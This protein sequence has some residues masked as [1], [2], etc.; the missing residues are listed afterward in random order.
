MSHC[1]SK[2]KKS[3]RIK[4]LYTFLFLIPLL[5]NA[6]Q[7]YSEHLGFKGN[8][9]FLCST[10]SSA[11]LFCLHFYL[12]YKLIK[13]GIDSST[14]STMNAKKTALTGSAFCF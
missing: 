4:K 3:A 1:L 11:G 13:K 9:M 2:A 6:L 12:L 14:Y 7:N 8:G 10:G 5:E